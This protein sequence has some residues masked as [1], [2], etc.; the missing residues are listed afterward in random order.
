MLRRGDTVFG[1]IDAGTGER[2][3]TWSTTESVGSWA[4]YAAVVGED[5]FAFVRQ[6]FDRPAEVAIVQQ[7]ADGTVASFRHEG[8]D[9]ARGLIGRAERLTWTASDGLEIDGFLLA[10]A[11]EGPHPLILYVHGGPVWSYAEWFPRPYLAWLVARGFAILMPNPRGSTGR[12]R[13]FLEAV[14]GDMGGGDAH[15]DLA[16]VDAVIERGFADPDRIA[17]TGGSYGGYMSCWLPVVDQRFKAAVAMSPVTDFYSEHWNSNIGAWDAWFLGG[18]P[19]DGTTQYQERSPV[20]LADRVRTPTFLTAGTED[21]CTP[22]GQAIEFYRALCAN[23]VPAEVAIYPG[24]GHGVRKLPAFLDL[25]TRSTAWFERFMPASRE[26]RTRGRGPDEGPRGPEFLAKRV[27]RPR[28]QG[29]PDQRVA[30][31]RLPAVEGVPRG[32]PGRVG[33]ERRP[34]MRWFEDLP[35]MASLKRSFSMLAGCDPDEVAL[36]TNISIALSTIA[37]CLDLSGD[38]RTVI[39]SGARLPHRWARLARMGAEDG[40]RGP[41]APQLRRAHDPGRGVRPR[42]RRADRARDG[43]SGPLPV[44]RDRRRQGSLRD[45]PRRGALSFVDDYHGLG[46][47]HWISTTSAATSTPP[48]SSSGCSADRGSCSSMPGAICSPRSSPPSRGGSRNGIRSP[49]MRSISTITPRRAAWSTARPGAVFFIAQGGID[50]I[51]EVGPAAI[52]VRNGELSDHVIARAD[53]RVSRCARRGTATPEAA[54]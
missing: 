37:S 18:E 46:S 5:G 36:T 16:G 10:P 15:D 20:F 54:S 24:E 50:I 12:G 31:S 3:E 19:Q 33:L 48:V 47:S 1:E 30:R 17:V 8:H 38:R 52:R 6:G 51:S 32:V 2:T 44:E 9:H 11:G 28:A 39:L 4:P 42:D 29:L 22:P 49:S 41:M 27:P 14:I 25:V 7:G 13:A 43:E 23:G 53:E 35:R 40:R 34:I 45:R 21:R 26:S